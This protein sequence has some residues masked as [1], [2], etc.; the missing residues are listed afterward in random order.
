MSDHQNDCDRLEDWLLDAEVR[1]QTPDARWLSHM[2]ECA[3][4]RAQWA[5]HQ[6]LV[7]T[8]ADD[9]VPELSPEFEAGLQGKLDAAVKV[10]PLSGWRLA[11]MAGYA[12]LAVIFMGWIF[13]EFPLP[14]IDTSSPWVVVAA[15]LAVPLSLWLTAAATR[16]LPVQRPK[17]ARMM[18]I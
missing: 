3:G 15:F 4:C 14:S 9:S 8:F 6:I 5:A 11:A 17:G 13:S 18:A 1:R 10:Q 2:E 12:V 7:A 16:L